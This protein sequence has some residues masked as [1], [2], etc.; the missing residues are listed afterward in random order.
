MRAELFI[1][2]LSMFDR[3]GDLLNLTTFEMPDILNFRK[4]PL[5]QRPPHTPSD[6]QAMPP[7]LCLFLF[8]VAKT[9]SSFFFVFCYFAVFVWFFFSPQFERDSTVYVYKLN[10][11][12]MIIL[13]KHS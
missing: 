1:R 3:S 2:E 11:D 12:E 7:L 4:Q 10:E 9:E 8:N 5:T 13:Y 6:D